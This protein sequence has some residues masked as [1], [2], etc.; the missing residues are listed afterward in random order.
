MKRLEYITAITKAM[1]TA[2]TYDP[3]LDAT[4]DTLSGILARRDQAQ[5]EIEEMG[6]N[7]MYTSR[8]GDARYVLNPACA[9]EGK[10]WAEARKYLDVL[11][12]TLG[13]VKA[14]ASDA[15]GGG[16]DGLS[17]LDSAINA[18]KPKVYK[19]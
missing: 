13:Q 16:N 9:V 14:S 19:P 11:H 15:D 5:S 7:L 12:L 1:Q 17:L 2:G 3:L 4:I 8:E 10:A 18:I 6:I